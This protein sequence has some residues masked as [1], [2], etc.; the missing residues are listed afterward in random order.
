[1]PPQLKFAWRQTILVGSVAGLCS[2]A[3]AITQFASKVNASAEYP[4]AGH[5]AVRYDAG[6]PFTYAH[7]ELDGLGA[8]SFASTVHGPPRLHAIF[9]GAFTFDVLLLALLFALALA[10]VAGLWSLA[11]RSR[12]GGSLKRFVQLAALG[13]VCATVWLILSSWLISGTNA[14]APT[15]AA[16]FTQITQPPAVL[17]LAPGV[18]QYLTQRWFAGDSGP[19]IALSG[20]PAATVAAATEI[21]V[22]VVLPAALLTLVLTNG[23]RLRDWWAK[24]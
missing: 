1:M 24:Q 12:P 20:G 4:S 10:I 14:E 22:S 11:W 5:G 16:T 9:W 19:A 13:L 2:A 18:G 21:L 17:Y 23:A 8:E 6:W 3:A 7:V 15:D